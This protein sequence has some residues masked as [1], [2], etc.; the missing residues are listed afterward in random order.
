MHVLELVRAERVHRSHLRAEAALAAVAAFVEHEPRLAGNDRAV[1]TCT[2]LELD[3]H[4]L[5]PVPD[6]DE[7]LA[8]GEDELDGPPRSTGQR[9][10][11]TFEVKVALG[12]DPAS[13]QRHDHPDV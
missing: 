4:A 3:H 12:A 9:G 2:G 6:R 10:A 13:E 5:A 7:L 11:V 8:P 1:R